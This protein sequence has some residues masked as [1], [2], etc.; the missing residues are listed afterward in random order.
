MRKLILIAC[1]ILYVISCD[2]EETQ[3]NGNNENIVQISGYRYQDEI[4]H[5]DA[6]YIIEDFAVFE[7]NLIIEEGTTI[8]FKED[9]SLIFEYGSLIA[10]GTKEKPIIF[11][12]LSE[13]PQ[14]GDWGNIRLGPNSTLSYCHIKFGG[15]TKHSSLLNLANNCNINNCIIE[16]S[17]SHGVS[18]QSFS[19]PEFRNN[20]IRNCD[21]HAVILSVSHVSHI[22]G[23]N[24]I[25]AKEGF[26]ILI[27]GGSIQ[28]TH[29]WPS[30][31]FPYYLSGIFELE[32]SLVCPTLILDP[33][34]IL[35]FSIGS[36]LCIGWYQ[37]GKLI[38]EGTLDQPIIFTSDS[39]NPIPGDWKGIWLGNTISEGTVLKHC[40]IEYVGKNTNVAPEDYPYGALNFRACSVNVC[41][42]NCIIQ[43]TTTHGIA[44]IN[45]A[46]TTLINNSFNNI[47]G[48]D[49]YIGNY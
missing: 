25:E 28:G 27:S 32:N 21:G 12:S 11:S 31:D 10:I 36:Y 29:R 41:V 4:W 26:G 18:I 47:A 40:I 5:S 45:N 38:A 42:E 39:D 17:A 3:P 7:S 20:T 43:N 30:Y 13:T 44:V 19:L 48:E 15:S 1:L 6:I 35:K 37:K 2:N 14:P 49:I 9:A 46:N 16:N 23:E 8:K 34:C 33:G 24:Q 22:T